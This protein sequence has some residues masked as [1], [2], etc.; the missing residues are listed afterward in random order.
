[1]PAD[2]ITQG[3]ALTECLAGLSAALA[4]YLVSPREIAIAYRGQPECL[5]VILV[6]P[7]L[8]EDKV[9]G[10]KCVFTTTWVISAYWDLDCGLEEAHAAI[11]TLMSGCG[12]AGS[13][14]CHLSNRDNLAPLRA[15]GVGIQKF[16][17]P[18]GFSLAPYGIDGAPNTYW[19]QVPITLTYSC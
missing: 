9:V 17:A 4:P 8:G 2:L 18:R 12:I 10:Q 15:A 6:R 14:L 1:M 7:A 5:P 11:Y 16:D 19:A 3:A 13:I